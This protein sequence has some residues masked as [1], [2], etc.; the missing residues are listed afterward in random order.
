MDAGGQTLAASDRS[1]IAGRAAIMSVKPVVSETRDIYQRAG[2]E[3]VHISIR[4]LDGTLLER[5]SADF[6]IYSRRFNWSPAEGAS[7]PVPNRAGEAIGY[8]TWLPFRPEGQVRSR[9]M[10]A[11][12]LA[13]LLVGAFLGWLLSRIWR[14][15]VN[16]EAS[17]SQAEHLA[18]HDALTGLR[19]RVLFENRLMHALSRRDVPTPAAV[20]PGLDRFKNV[21]DKFGHQAGDALI[22]EL[23]ARLVALLREEDTIARLGSD[24]FASLIEEATDTNVTLVW[25]RVLGAVREPFEEPGSRAFVAVSLGV[26]LTSAS[27]AA[28][29]SELTRRADI[30]LYRSKDEGRNRYTIFA[31]KMDASVRLRASIEEDLRIALVTGEGLRVHY[32]PLVGGGSDSIVG[33]EAL[34]R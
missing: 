3:Y 25:E 17:R 19:N 31:E 1:V 16:L 12:S 8:I 27:A 7:L 33:L 18:F 20:L 10:P 11:I 22:R 21:N 24:E 29:A 32:Q 13:L 14:N 4:Y 30:A 34:A 9:M 6:G 23:G 26:A 28:N 5:L 2:A 15:H